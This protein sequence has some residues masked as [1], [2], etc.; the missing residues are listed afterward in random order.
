VN[1]GLQSHNEQSHV[2]TVQ[3]YRRTYG[4][5]LDCL[6]KKTVMSPELNVYDIT[7]ISKQHDIFLN[8]YYKMFFWQ[9]YRTAAE[10]LLANHN[11]QYRCSWI[12]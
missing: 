4:R 10:F 12:L 6:S 8:S 5:L 1:V 7:S 3:A 11:D 9:W 2:Y